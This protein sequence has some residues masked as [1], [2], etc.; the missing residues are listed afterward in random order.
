M[1]Y[2]LLCQ[3]SK[4]LIELITVNYYVLICKINFNKIITFK[5]TLNIHKE[6]WDWVHYLPVPNAIRLS[7]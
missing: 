3:A 4:L 1:M 7:K 5:F 2:L 6:I